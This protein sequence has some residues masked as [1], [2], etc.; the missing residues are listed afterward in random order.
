MCDVFSTN[1]EWSQEEMFENEAWVKQSNDIAELMEKDERG[2]VCGDT[3]EDVK[4]LLEKVKVLRKERVELLEEIKDLR[5]FHEPDVAQL[6]KDN[7]QQDV[8]ADHLEEKL[9]MSDK[10]NEE[11]SRGYKRQQVEIA[12]LKAGIK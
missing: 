4:E 9:K 12:I 6:I 11:L 10:L 5:V 7:K 1:E 3:L 8:Y 2:A